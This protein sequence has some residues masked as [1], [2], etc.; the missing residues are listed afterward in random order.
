[1]ARIETIGTYTSS[2]NAISYGTVLANNATYP[3]NKKLKDDIFIFNCHEKY[4]RKKAKVYQV[5]YG[6]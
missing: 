1:M 5:A 2:G 4:A 3:L 6:E